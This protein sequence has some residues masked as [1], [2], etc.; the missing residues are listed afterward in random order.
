MNVRV[1]TATEKDIPFILELYQQLSLVPGDYPKPSLEQCR[2]I[3][4]KMKE[5]HGYEL[6]VAEESGKVVGTTVLAVLP[7]FAHGTSS[8]AVAEYLVVDEKY[9]RQGIGKLLMSYCINRAKKSGCYKIMLTSD[10]RRKDAHRFY[11]SLGFETSA[12]GFRMYF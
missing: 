1:R 4:R 10:N 9:R 2:N 12:Q 11:L 6:L 7:G 8:F 3:L 5:L